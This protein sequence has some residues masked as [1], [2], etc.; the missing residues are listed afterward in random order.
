MKAFHSFWSAPNRARHGGKIV[1]A[2]YEL[3]TMMLSALMWR[4]HSGEIRMAADAA[5]KAYLERAGLGALWSEPI[6][7]SLERLDVDPVRFWAAGKLEALRRSAAPCVMLDTDLILWKSVT[8]RLTDC[9][10]AAHR[11]ELSEEAYPAPA[12]AFTLDE[13]YVFPPDWDFTQ[14]PA[15]TAFLYLPC[16]ELRR[17]YTHEAFR[18]M[19]ALRDERRGC[20]ATMCFAEQRILP[21]CADAC[22]VAVRTLLDERA[23]DEQSFVTHLWGGKRALEQDPGQRVAYCL[24]CTLRLM[25]DFPEW[26]G[27]LAANE[28]TRVYLESL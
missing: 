3:L 2:D 22:G 8:S 1:L 17:V 20:V 27:V 18:F 10:V 21:M 15:N 11:E 7:A 14:K 25:T 6:D 19:R 12:D 9:V 24:Q 5:G 4:R 28:Q 26:E 13:D 16:E 23:P